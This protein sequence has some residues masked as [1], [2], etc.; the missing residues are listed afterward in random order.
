MNDAQE[1]ILYLIVT[2]AVTFCV[3]CLTGC[4]TQAKVVT[5][6]E[7]RDRVQRDTLT[8]TDSVYIARYVREKGDTVFVT[9]TLFR[10]RYLDKVRDVYVH[11]SVP[12]EVQVQV[13]VRVRNGYDRFTSW[14]FWILLVL[15]LSRFAWWVVKKYYLRA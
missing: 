4:S 1:F 9:D 11:D 10:F 8:R 6:T 14:G 2:V 15:L 7:Y 3:L 13:P 5:V 12:Y